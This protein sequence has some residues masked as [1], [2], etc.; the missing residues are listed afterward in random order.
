MEIRQALEHALA[1]NGD[2]DLSG[3]K[4]ALQSVVQLSDQVNETI[5]RWL[6]QERDVE[7]TPH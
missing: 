5:R 2:N 3:A 7:G 1:V 6:E 4:A